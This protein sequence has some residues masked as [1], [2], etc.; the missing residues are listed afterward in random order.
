M[1]TSIAILWFNEGHIGFEEVLQVLDIL[2][3]LELITMS[4]QRDQRRNNRM[5]GK[6]TA[7]TQ[8]RRHC[9]AKKARVEEEACKSSK[10]TNYG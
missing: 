9:A 1:A 10:V 5:F 3:T 6:Q 2:S 4:K 7:E 8:S